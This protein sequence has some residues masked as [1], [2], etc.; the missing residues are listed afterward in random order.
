MFIPISHD[1]LMKET[2]PLTCVIVPDPERFDVADVEG[3]YG[4][5]VLLIPLEGV[6]VVL[7]A[8]QRYLASVSAFSEHSNK[9]HGI[10]PSAKLTTSLHQ[11]AIVLLWKPQKYHVRF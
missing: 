3:V 11:H 4:E 9:Y 1:I 5:D 7:R 8:S 10:G 6:L 2:N